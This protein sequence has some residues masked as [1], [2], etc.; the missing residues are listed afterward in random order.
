MWFCLLTGGG[1]LPC[2]APVVTLAPV[3]D[4]TLSENY[5]DNN[6]GAMPFANSGTT[7]NYTRN[8]ALFRFDVAGAL[9]AGA[10]ITNA[11]L[12]LEVVGQPGES[13]ASGHFNLHRVLRPWGEGNQ[14]NAPGG[15]SGQGSPATTN[16]ATWHH[17]F[18]F[19]T[20]LWAQPGAAPTNDFVAQPSS[21]VTV[22]GVDQSP[23]TIPATPLMLADLQ[24]WL[25]QPG[26]NFGWLL[27]C[28]Q[29]GTAF[30]ARRFG[31]RE[32]PLNAPR[33][34]LDYEILPFIDSA[35]RIGNE[36]TLSFLAQPGWFYTVEYRD[37]PGTNAWQPLAYASTPADPVRFSITDRTDAPQ[38]FYR[39]VAS[40]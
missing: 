36:F 33:L 5:P 22:F 35:Q 20:N 39:L 1:L 17:R 40:P 25:R 24:L 27:V 18:A 3:A 2:P 15:G 21:G 16:E 34:E 11:S 7:Q 38:R 23:Y 28:E 8:R 31:T 12:I 14:V 19:T 32:D 4:T 13:P 29:E 10:N 37:A 30:T 26:T 9:P 6:F